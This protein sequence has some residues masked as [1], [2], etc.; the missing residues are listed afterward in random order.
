MPSSDSKEDQ[1]VYIPKKEADKKVEPEVVTI[2][3]ENTS[4]IIKAVCALVCVAMVILVVFNIISFCQNQSK[5]G[6]GSYITLQNKNANDTKKILKDFGK[7]NQ[8]KLH[9]YSF[10]GSKLFISE[11]KIEANNIKN[12]DYFFN[13]E[14]SGGFLLYNMLTNFR[15]ANSTNFKNNQL[16][17]DFNQC[18]IGDYFIYPENEKESTENK[19]FNFYSLFSDEIIENQCYSLPKKDGKRCRIQLKNNTLSPYTMVSVLDA[20]ETLPGDVYDIVLFNNEYIDGNKKETTDE[21]IQ[22]LNE[23]IS[24][25]EFEENYNL[26]IKI[27]TSLQD[28]ISTKANTSICYYEDENT[29]SIYSSIF[30]SC[31][32]SSYET[33]VED[34]SSSLSG[35]DKIAE[36]RECV[37][38]LDRAGQSNYNVIGNDTKQ[39]GSQIG[40]DAYMIKTGKENLPTLLKNLILNL[41]K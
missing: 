31:T 32:T 10:L 38:Y 41:L 25:I 13:S 29:E 20:G 23:S 30:T 9:D 28:A 12:Q 4:L 37:G 39:D 22:F 16:Y 11:N 36:I 7:E 1:E 21:N 15:N 33:E 18:Q 19:D 24:S 27:A 6:K 3:S 14:N 17:I 2:Y 5:T 8:K 35:Y 40:K 34:E 26:K